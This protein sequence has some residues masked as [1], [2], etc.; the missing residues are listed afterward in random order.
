M[1]NIKTDSDDQY[2][3]TKILTIWA[4]VAVPMPIM[5]FWIAPV[6]ADRFNTNPLLLIWYFM[7]VGMV[8]QFLL[9]VWLLH[10]E[11]D[12]FTWMAI[13]ERIWLSKPTDPR[14]GKSSYKLFWW[15]I[16]AFVFLRGDRR[17]SSRRYNRTID[18][19][20]FPVVGGI[21]GAGST[22]SGQGGICR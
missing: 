3:L 5:A 8:W 10:R 7:I 15:L 14:T 21:T 22:R 17:N 16:P 11:L 2:S 12:T 13:R 18:T 20:P 9:S 4:A 1:T 19:S 6:L